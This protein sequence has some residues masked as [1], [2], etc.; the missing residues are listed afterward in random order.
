M[1]EMA[2]NQDK[3]NQT[4]NQINS[5]QGKVPYFKFTEGPNVV[6]ILPGKEPRDTFWEE[7]KRS[8]S[9][10]PNNRS[11]I[12]LSQFGRPCPLQRYIDELLSRGDEASRKEAE[13]MRPKPRF[14]FFI[15]DRSAEAEGPKFMEC[16]G[17]LMNQ[18]LSIVADPDYGD[19]SAPA[20]GTD[21]T[22]SYTPGAKTKNG[23]PEYTVRA[24]RNSSPLT[25]DATQY[26]DWTGKDLFEEYGIGQPSDEEYIIKCIRG[27]ETDGQKTDEWS[28]GQAGK[29]FWV[30]S[31]G[32][33]KELFGA[34]IMALV[35]GGQNPQICPCD[36]PGLGWKL[37]TELGFEPPQLATPP[38]APQ[39]PPPT[40]PSLPS[41]PP[42]PAPPV[43]PSPP[44]MAV[45]PPS[46]PVPPSMPWT[47]EPNGGEENLPFDSAPT[48][49]SR[50][51]DDLRQQL[52]LK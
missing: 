4:R 28:T 9:V 14:G 22:I 17:Q 19:I 38:A 51:G 11:V 10:G 33:T 18:I 8:H 12:P 5:S 39:L 20:N 44:V 42:M 25:S 30:V 43:V 45:G 23:F 47:N 48:A 36:N 37:A 31:N 3:V 1:S 29:K 24:K 35:A 50:V 26:A 16:S 41:A 13:K 52:G 34:D 7:Y 15:I 27:E 6:R 32:V 46:P 21:L 2:L 40:A 49:T